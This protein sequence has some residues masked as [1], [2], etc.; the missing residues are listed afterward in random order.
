MISILHDFSLFQQLHA[1]IDR[2][3]MVNQIAGGQSPSWSL[4]ELHEA[5]VSLVNYSTPCLFAAQVAINNTMRTL[6]EQGGFLPP[7]ESGGSGI[8]ECTAILYD[9]LN[10]RDKQFS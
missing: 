1:Q 4:R 5:G 3:L 7:L 8:Q 9:N 10:R 2:P 6:K